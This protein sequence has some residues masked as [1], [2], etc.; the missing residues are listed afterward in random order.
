[1]PFA[2]IDRVCLLRL[3]ALRTAVK[4]V[5]LKVIGIVP[6]DRRAPLLECATAL[7]RAFVAAVHNASG[8]RL[9]LPGDP[10]GHLF[11]DPILTPAVEVVGN[12]EP[13]VPAIDWKA[14]A[15][16]FALAL[17]EVRTLISPPPCG[18]A[19]G[20]DRCLKLRGLDAL[21]VSLRGMKP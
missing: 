17:F 3:E 7:D 6:G 10:S 8:D 16:R 19:C 4:E 2:N 20:H 14:E 5:T 11:T 18:D 12:G 21:L 1:M 13:E 9:M 15:K